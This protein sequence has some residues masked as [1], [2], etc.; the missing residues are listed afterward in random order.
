MNLYSISV[1]SLS[2][3]FSSVTSSSRA[4]STPAIVAVA[5]FAVT[6]FLELEAEEETGDE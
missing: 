3:R 2:S 4:L 6:L 5:C 1:V